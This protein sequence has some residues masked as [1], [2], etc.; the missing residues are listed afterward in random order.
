MIARLIMTGVVVRYCIL[1]LIFVYLMFLFMYLQVKWMHL[2]KN[3]Q[4]YSYES[5][6][7]FHL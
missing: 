1:V 2:N 5:C 6:D 4:K 3:T 7:H